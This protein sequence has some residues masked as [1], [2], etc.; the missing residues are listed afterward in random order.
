MFVVDR[1]NPLSVKDVYLEIFKNGYA[2]INFVKLLVGG[3]H[4]Y[5]K[6]FIGVK[7]FKDLFPNISL[8]VNVG[9]THIEFINKVGVHK[10]SIIDS[11]V[12]ACGCLEDNKSYRPIFDLICGFMY[13]FIDSVLYDLYDAY[14]ST[15]GEFLMSAY[16]NKLILNEDS[17]CEIVIEKN[18]YDTTQLA[19]AFMLLKNGS[20]DLI[21]DIIE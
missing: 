4:Y 10:H 19:T 8:I 11:I 15:D 3:L 14:L 17:K 2:E 5:D 9:N 6:E 18:E 7:I 21:K 16:D 20:P 12:K 1:K 13:E